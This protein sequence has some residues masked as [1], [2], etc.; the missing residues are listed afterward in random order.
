MKGFKSIFLMFY[1]TI[2]E[3][4]TKFKIKYIV[5][6]LYHLICLKMYKKK[7]MCI[8]KTNLDTMLKPW[9]LKPRCNYIIMNDCIRKNN[10]LL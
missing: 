8:L 3:H 7:N 10:L 2:N 4:D 9:C 6:L 5:V 1:H